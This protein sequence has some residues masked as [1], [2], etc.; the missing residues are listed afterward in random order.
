MNINNVS[1]ETP[2]VNTKMRQLI[3]KL[4]RASEA[5][6]KYDNPI[7][8]DRDYD[9]LYDE[10]TALEQETGI[11]YPSSPTQ[12]VQ[13][14]ILD[15][16]KKVTHS[17]PMLSAAKTKDVEE[18]RKFVGNN[19]Y[20]VS[21]KLDGLTLVVKY[22]DGKLIQAITRGNGIEGEDVTE[23]AKM[24]SNLPI[25]IPY[26]EY[27]ELRGECLIS[28]ET[29]RKINETLEKPYKHPRNL[30]AGTIRTLDTGII[31]DRELAFLV[32]ECV[33]INKPFESKNE[34]LSYLETLGFQ[35]VQRTQTNPELSQVNFMLQYVEGTY[36]VD[37]LIFEL[38]NIKLSSSLGSTAH[39]ENCRIA[40]KWKDETEDTTVTD[41]QWQI[42]RTGVLTP[43]A[44]FKPVE[45]DGTTVSQALVH[46]VTYIKDMDLNVGSS[47]AVAKMNMIIPQI[48]ENY[49]KNTQDTHYHIPEFCPE[50]NSPT[51]IKTLEDTAV[52]YCTNP[53]CK[54]KILKMFVWFVSKQGMNINGLSEGILSKLYEAGLLKTYA[55]IY[56]LSQHTE[57][58][59]S[60]VDKIGTKLWK[61]LLDN[62]EKS[63]VCKLEN[64]IVAI[65]IPTIGKSTAKT[66]S[67]ACNGSWRI[68]ED[69]IRSGF[70]FCTLE[71]IGTTTNTAIYDWY[72]SDQS[73]WKDCIDMLAFETVL[74][75]N[76][77]SDSDVDS[78]LA[79]FKN[80]TVVVTGT[81]QNYSR[82]NIQALLEA[83]GAHC[84]GSVSRKT[85]YLLKGEKA[86][87]K[88]NKAVELK[89][90][91]ITE[92]E[93]M[94]I[95][96]R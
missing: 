13:G 14:F 78:P 9:K 8:S 2:D 33:K 61:K 95:L 58:V 84:S 12:K 86:G 72:N 59:L 39:H 16:L 17:K 51:V 94:Q 56:T 7:M 22:E 90:P 21:Y 27:L 1:T 71:D 92:E 77:I 52:L 53:D 65:G 35:A 54:G 26:K 4:T 40:F 3:K 85:D 6:Y 41:I 47:V 62:I 36:P 25:N 42:G 30:A 48:V 45:L 66:I 75:S 44:V 10:L 67:K 32:F 87:S 80:K 63:R 46:N 70:N 29:F 60:T 89:V 18:C 31:K 49:S 11:I 93:F 5:Y 50:C 43:V 28:W 24:I 23:A 73:M 68:F 19:D 57:T 37:G 64:F 38:D 88:F 15:G 34:C 79:M 96:S 69:K 76:S 83:A 82:E 74:T 91:I 20:Y 55:D 81:F